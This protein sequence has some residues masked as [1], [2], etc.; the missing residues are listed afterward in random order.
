MSNYY[1]LVYI[2]SLLNIIFCFL[3]LVFQIPRFIAACNLVKNEWITVGEYVLE[4][5]KLIAYTGGFGIYVILP[6]HAEC[7]E[8]IRKN[9]NIR[10]FIFSV[11]LIV[12]SFIDGTTR[13]LYHVVFFSFLNLFASIYVCNIALKDYNNEDENLEQNNSTEMTEMSKFEV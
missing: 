3:L 7:F 8:S 9:F 1:K 4:L 13:R 10:Y 5:F 6:C 2:I 11:L 12:M